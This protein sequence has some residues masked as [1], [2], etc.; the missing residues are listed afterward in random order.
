MRLLLGSLL[1][2]EK[3]K[4]KKNAAKE[5]DESNWD[6]GGEVRF[7]FEWCRLTNDDDDVDDVD[8]ETSFFSLLR[9]HHLDRLVMPSVVKPTK[10]LFYLF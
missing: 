1:K 7:R 4:K 10:A 6:S 3:E 5:R 2:K 9:E 8:T